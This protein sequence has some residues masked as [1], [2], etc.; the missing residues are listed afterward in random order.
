MPNEERPDQPLRAPQTGARA[1]EAHTYVVDDFDSDVPGPQTFKS[2][3][4]AIAFANQDPDN[5]AVIYAVDDVSTE[6]D[7]ERTSPGV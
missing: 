5:T 1:V 2:L 4:E 3:A 6:T 7:S